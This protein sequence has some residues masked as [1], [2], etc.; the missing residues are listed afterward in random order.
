M[1]KH[2]ALLALVASVALPPHSAA[3][4]EPVPVNPALFSAKLYDLNDRSV[5]LERFRG[6]PLVINFW[7]RW[8]DPCRR[9]IPDLIGER[10]RLKRQGLEVIGIGIEDDAVAVKEF[11]K[12]NGIDYPVLLAKSEGMAL[13]QALGNLSAGLPYTLVLD[14]QGRVL[15]RRLGEMQKA[16]MAS[17]F[18]AAVK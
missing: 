10:A 4:T 14:R 7:A 9:E 18:D 16:E 12:A 15:T 6:R 11:V 2:F 8:C 1:I 3:A 17:A 5:T 13:L